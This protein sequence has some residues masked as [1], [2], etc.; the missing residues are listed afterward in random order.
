MA[1]AKIEI[2]VGAVSFS[3]E[4]NEGWLAT[5]LDK[6][7]KHLPDLVKVA[8]AAS[9]ASA[10]GA[11]AGAGAGIGGGAKGASGTLKSFLT[12]TGSTSNSTR[13]FLA[14]ALWL[15]DGGLDKLTTA[16]VSKAVSDNKQGGLGN[17][18]QCLANNV[19]QGF[20]QKVGKKDFYVTEEGKTEL[21]Q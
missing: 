9:A 20:C 6:M 19:K 17:A 8:P 13:K 12:A 5:Q 3:G 1:E 11:G 16:D 18:S 21:N 4:G 10:G 15:Q 2:K 7:I 14:T